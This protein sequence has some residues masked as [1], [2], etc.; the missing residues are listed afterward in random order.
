MHSGRISDDT[1]QLAANYSHSI[2]SIFGSY[3]YMYMVIHSL[4]WGRHP[5]QRDEVYV[6]T[7]LGHVE[8]NFSSGQSDAQTPFI[9]TVCGKTNGF[10]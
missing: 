10:P 4:L 9:C 3:M 1:Y 6:C 5:A 2:T 8:M 7:V